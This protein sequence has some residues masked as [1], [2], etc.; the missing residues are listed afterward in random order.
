MTQIYPNGAGESLGHWLATNSPLYLSGNLWYVDSTNGVDAASPAG[1]NRNKPLKTLG[2][3]L[4]NIAARDVIVLMDNFAETFTSLVTVSKQCAIVGAGSSGGK[5]TAKLTNN[6]SGTGGL[7]DITAG[8]VLLGNLWIEENLH[9]TANTTARINVANSSFR[10]E[11]CY[12]ECGID[13]AGPA[14]LLAG[15]SE[16][17]TIQ[18]TTFIVTSTDTANQPESAI[19]NTAVALS[20]IHLID[21]TVDGGVAGFSNFHAIDFSASDIAPI[22]VKTLSLLRGADLKRSSSVGTVGFVNVSKQTGSA[23]VE[24]P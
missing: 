1:Q 7:L 8:D 9:T 10:M 17:S 18:N 15:G 24:W 19:K 20:N 3:A 16:R 4:T 13:D 5:P 22:Y 12:V 23:R 21:V 2:Q 14:V 6:Q 11:D